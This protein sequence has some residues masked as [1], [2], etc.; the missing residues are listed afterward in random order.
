MS[1]AGTTR[2]V[3]R[4]ISTLLEE[5][6]FRICELDLGKVNR[7]ETDRFVEEDL[8]SAA[9]LMI[10]S[11]AYADHILYPVGAF[12]DGLPG[13]PGTPALVFSTFGGVS[14]GVT[15]VQMTEK[16]AVKGYLVKGAAKVLC[17]HS[18][19][20]RSE[21]PMSKGHPGDVDWEVLDEWMGKVAGRLSA[22]DPYRLDSRTLRSSNPIL[23][24]LVSTVFNMRVI[25]ALIPM[26]RFCSARC[27]R[28]GACR[29][30]CP[31][32]RLDTLPPLRGRKGC[33]YCLECVRV[34]PSAAF[35]APM[36]VVHPFVR[37]MKRLLARWEEQRT[38]YYL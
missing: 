24:L 25:G 18:M 19:F 29:T 14:K 17:V 27:R 26:Y 4:R 11:P 21:R 35:D 37:V 8:T 22:E 36:W 5:R 31:T 28:C 30:Q 7:A 16:L 20:F 15:L 3:S 2:K 38:K 33:L 32:G 13:A 6:G 9:L 12:L 34:C 23:R 1:P 10:G